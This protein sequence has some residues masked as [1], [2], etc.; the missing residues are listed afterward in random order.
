VTAA[1]QKLDAAFDAA[2]ALNGDKKTRNN[3]AE[4]VAFL[5][6]L[7]Q[8]YTRLL[9]TDKKKPARKWTD[10]AHKDYFINSI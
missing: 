3:D 6:K 8:R 4:R 5:F 9:T 10:T 1:H 7:Y 2:Y